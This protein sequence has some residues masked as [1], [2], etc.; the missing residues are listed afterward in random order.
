MRILSR[1]LGRP[2]P[3]LLEPKAAYARWAETYPPRAHNALMR[4]EQAAMEAMLGSISASAVLDLGT[5]TG[6][7]LPVLAKAGARKAIGLDRSLAMLASAR[8]AGAPLVCADA[9]ALPFVTEAFD[10]VVASLMVGDVDDLRQWAR[11]IWRA[12]KPGGRLLYSDF[13]PFWAE[14]NWERTFETTDGRSWR[15]NYHPHAIVEHQAALTAAG[16]SVVEIRQPRL[17]H[18]GDGEVE[19]MR[20]RWNNPSVS[21]VVHA[22][23]P[24]PSPRLATAAG[25]R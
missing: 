25:M 7:Y 19:A 3:R 24:G 17:I 14:R 2:R 8:A 21:V 15:V 4:S 13:H 12:L 16:F 1:L 10:L 5:G 20:A 11:E 18:D 22:A 23:K 9:C 6:R